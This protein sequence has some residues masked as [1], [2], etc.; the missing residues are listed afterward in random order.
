M[1]DIVI[2]GRYRKTWSGKIRLELSLE[3]IRTIAIQLGFALLKVQDPAVQ[4]VYDLFQTI[5]NDPD[6]EDD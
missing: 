4:G 2:R 6:M 1:S 5:L 3:D